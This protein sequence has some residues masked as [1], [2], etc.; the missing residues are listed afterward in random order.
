MGCALAV[1]GVRRD[2]GETDLRWAS[3]LA[4]IAAG[5]EA[6]LDELYGQSSG[7][8]HSLALRILRDVSS[9][10][11]VTLEVYL[12]VWRRAPSFDPARGTASTWL[13]M[14]ARSRA[15]DRLRSG[16]HRAQDRQR[17]LD[18]LAP[19]RDTAPDPE[20]AADLAGRQALVRRALGGL[21]SE[22]REVI[23]LAYFGGLSQS[24]IAQRSG[25]PL[26]TVK[27]RMRLA[28]LK[29]RDLVE[30]HARSL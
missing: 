10:E 19:L 13:F 18:E 20:Q 22:Q 9:A 23:E 5:D 27:T 28:M 1:A 11:D 6:A 17:P 16:A 12:Q 4:R 29:L 7:I 8:V 21:P 24:E 2:S 30:P 14:L 26:G 25:A 3:L 15:I